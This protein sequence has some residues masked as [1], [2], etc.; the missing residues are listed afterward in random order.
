MT[1][2]IWTNARVVTADGPIDRVPVA[3]ALEVMTEGGRIVAVGAGLSR[4]G[5]RIVDCG[6]RLLSP[7]PVD[8]HTHIVFGGD[9]A[10]EF[11]MRLD[12][13]PY[14]QIAQAGGGIRA[15]V[16][17]TRG[18]DIAGLVR[19]A[20]PRLDHLLAEGVSTV[21]VKSGYGLSVEAE[22]NML[23]AA[24]A[25]AQARP[26]R[27]VTTWLAAH[28]VPPEYDGRP[29]AYISEV[30]IPGLKAAHAEGLVDAVDSFCESIAFTTEHLAPL[31]DQAR[32]LGL[33]VK[34]HSEQLS[35]SGGTAFA[36]RYGALSADHLEHAT[37][38][39]AQAMA[40]AGT[41]AVL[42][43]GAF[44]M[45]RETALPPVA[46]FRTAGVPM[47]LATDCNPGTS[48]LTSILLAMNMG[49]TLFRLSVAEC[50][51]GVT[52]H[53]ARA[54]G[55]A[56]ETGRIAPGLSADMVLWNVET[57]AQLVGRI[58]FNPLHA[59]IFQGRVVE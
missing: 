5:C 45:L 57:P 46:S 4:K 26:V 13:V 12:G 7:A 16:R 3:G 37:E 44:Y 34:I 41:V 23:R 54:L 43:P 22:L 50:L 59:R 36:C 11:E 18:M 53:A 31:Y 38:Q 51:L 1:A 58:G 6:G 32:S 52:A 28:A 19:A 24:R 20:L 15:S 42:L 2:A 25:L 29:E 27:I 35:H 55:L 30:A 10:N 14:A 17:A 39:D 21:E 49:A 56:H 8:C 47:A 48:P 9:R 40:Q 33:P